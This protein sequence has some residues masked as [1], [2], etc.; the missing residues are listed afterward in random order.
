MY[1]PISFLNLFLYVALIVGESAKTNCVRWK[2]NID[3]VKSDLLQRGCNL[4][5]GRPVCCA[6][7]EDLPSSSIMEGGRGVGIEGTLR[8]DKPMQC[9]TKKEY[10]PSRY[11]QMHFRVASSL[12]TIPTA[13]K[14]L[15]KLL[16]FLS[17]PEEVCIHLFVV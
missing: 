7:V 13:E 8:W 14:R 2:T 11:E 15:E 10:H 6:A 9:T 5:D 16:Q 3:G 17:S 12:S 1:T 4:P